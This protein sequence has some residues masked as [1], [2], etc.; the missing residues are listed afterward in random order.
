MI[1]LENKDISNIYLRPVRI[2]G[3]NSVP[4]RKLSR[5]RTAWFILGGIF[6]YIIA[7]L[8]FS[9]THQNQEYSKRHNN[10]PVFAKIDSQ[11]LSATGTIKTIIPPETSV[12]PPVPAPIITKA[13]PA[14]APKLT[15]PANLKLS[16]QHGDTL[17]SMLT[18]RGISPEEA[19]NIV[20][21][22]KKYYNPRNLAVGQ[23][24]NISLDKNQHDESKTILTG[25]SVAVSPLKTI[26]MSRTINKSSGKE[27]FSIKEIKAPVTKGYGHAGGIIRSSL[28]QTASDAGLPANMINEIINALSYDV[29]FQRDIHKGDEID[30]VFERMHTEKDITTGLGKILYVSLKLDDREITL[31]RHTAKDGFSGYYN[32]KGES[33]KKALLK[34]PINGAHITS[35]FGMRMHPL[36]GYSKMHKGI[37]FGAVTG[38]PIYA[39]G[40]GVVEEAG[41]K[42]GY[43]NYV[44]IKHSNQYSTAYGHASRIAKGIKTGAHV[45]QGQVIAYVGSSG[46]STGPHLHYE[47]MANGAQVNPA[48]VKFRTGNTLQGKEMAEFKRQ[49]KQIEVAL[50][51]IP[52]K[53]QLAIR[54]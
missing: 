18:E 11:L 7:Y 51:K 6:G 32:V 54:D 46:Q 37:D 9:Y 39:A 34:T 30:V 8:I 25:L 49:T 15:L 29:D 5:L 42:G 17:L 27:S 36:L 1:S 12:N 26:A 28:Y 2:D 40:E 53:T 13:P 47:I 43:G 21:S 20:L 10:P 52:R 50:A 3:R 35:S 23:S 16:V 4:T 44:K 22:M 41:R 33:V 48:G 24:L 38:T 19:N 45:K 14:P 31:Y